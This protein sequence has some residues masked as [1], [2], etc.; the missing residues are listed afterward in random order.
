MAEQKAAQ[1]S[2]RN[3][4]ISV[5]R[6]PAVNGTIPTIGGGD[7][8]HCGSATHVGWARSILLRSAPPRLACWKCRRTKK[9]VAN[10]KGIISEAS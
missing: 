3:K 6:V 2:E 1:Q 4:L 9:V 7:F 5:R 8:D 10:P